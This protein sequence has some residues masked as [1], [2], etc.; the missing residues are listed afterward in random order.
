M[1]TNNDVS[2]ILF[3]VSNTLAG[4]YPN[5]YTCYS[6]H[7]CA[8][9][10]V[11]CVICQLV[12]NVCNYDDNI[13]KQLSSVGRINVRR[14]PDKTCNFRASIGVSI[15]YMRYAI[16]TLYELPMCMYNDCMRECA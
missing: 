14:G 16:S 5:A 7:I 10:C 15:V 8:N 13:K 6:D 3:W 1:E 2:N 9:Y 12:V 4:E 11:H